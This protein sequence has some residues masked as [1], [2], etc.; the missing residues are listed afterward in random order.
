VRGW[1]QKV[2]RCRAYT[3]CQDLRKASNH[4][5]VGI[6]A[7]DG[8]AD[9]LTNLEAEPE[10]AEQRTM[11]SFEFNKIAGAVLGALLFGMATG[12]VADA[13]FSHEKPT[14]PGYDLPGEQVAST[15]VGTTGAATPAEP[16]PE[17]LA[18]ADPK[19]G[20]ADT[21]ACQACHNFEKGGAAKVGPPLYGVVERAKASIAGFDYS[22][23]L[24]SKGGEWSYEDLNTF[25][26]DPKAYASGTKMAFAG[27]K[28][29]QKRAE[30]LAYLRSLA[31]SPAPLPK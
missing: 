8:S 14:K 18:K 11:D 22:A 3:S 28:D 5:P 7:I 16:L 23:A 10:E 31:E 20:E 13:I 26:T 17:L 24:K 30:I 25:I 12:V 9:R 4:R 21:K 27:V 2:A 15:E 1:R 6:G 19:K 29:A